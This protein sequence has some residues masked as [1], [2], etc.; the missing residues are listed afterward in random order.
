MDTLVQPSVA[1]PAGAPAGGDVGRPPRGRDDE[2]DRATTVFLAQ[3][4]QLIRIAHRFL[5]GT[6]LAEDVV[7][8]AW[9]RWQRT[10]GR[11][12]DPPAFLATVTSRLAIN[13]LQ[14]APARHET[15]G[16]GRQ[17][18]LVDPAGAPETRAEVRESVE[19]ALR[20]LLERLDPAERAAFIL[21][22][23]FGYPYPE[24]ARLLD[25]NAVHARQLV[26]RARAHLRSPRRR[27]VGR[28]EHRRLLRAFGTASSAGEFAELETLLAA[29]LGRSAA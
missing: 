29:D 25:L 18:V 22:T 5:G 15:T 24:I 19:L 10:A 23:G 27:P 6:G 26:S 12:V 21:R 16:T 8:E 28:D 13:A 3:R 4:P 14:S 20:L 9:V 1:T 7:Q 11:V 17:E 2:L